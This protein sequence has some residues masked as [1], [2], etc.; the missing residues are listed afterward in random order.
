ALATK[1][2]TVEQ[3]LRFRPNHVYAKNISPE[4]DGPMIHVAWYDAAAYCNWLSALE[5]IPESEW[6]YP[7]KV[8]PGKVLPQAYLGKTGYRLPTEAEW[9]YA[10]RA[11]TATSR[12]YGTGEDLLHEYAWYAK[13]TNSQLVHP[14]GLLK[15]NDFGLFDMLGNVWEWCQEPALPYPL[16]AQ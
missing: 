3:F 8:G 6:C 14:G 4:P 10:C 12:F 1:E 15:P 2:V 5:R 16:L 13:S 11:G 7:K 9:E